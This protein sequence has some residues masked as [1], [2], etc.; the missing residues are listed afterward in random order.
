MKRVIAI[1]FLFIFLT[2]NTAFGQLLRLPTLVHHYFEHVEWDNSTLIEFLSKHYASTINHP[3]DQ[4]HDHEK[5]PFKA[6]DCQAIQV[7]TFIPQS[8]FSIAQIIFNTVE[9]KKPIFNQQ[10]YSNAYLNSIWQP[11][12]FS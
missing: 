11:P 7:L 8:T 12:R 10:N 1:P 5:L 6:L 2:A 9:I 4:H 3:D